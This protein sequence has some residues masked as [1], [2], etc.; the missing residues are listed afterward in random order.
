[1]HSTSSD[2][3]GV[4]IAHGYNGTFVDFLPTNTFTAVAKCKVSYPRD[5][6]GACPS[7]VP[8]P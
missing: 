8:C 7:S 1:M 2:S 4:G 5:D 3:A 6:K